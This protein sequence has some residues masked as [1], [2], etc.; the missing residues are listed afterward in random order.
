VTYTK[1]LR[2]FAAE[3]DRLRA[4]MVDADDELLELHDRHNR[5][6]ALGREGQAASDAELI[7]RYRMDNPGTSSLEAYPAE[8]N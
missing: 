7:A 4:A 6:T 1:A 2:A 8:E 5:L 3:L